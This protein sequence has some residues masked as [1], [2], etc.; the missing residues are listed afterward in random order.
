MF[1]DIGLSNGGFTAPYTRS[2]TR[3]VHL[4]KNED[5]K[6]NHQLLEDLK[7]RKDKLV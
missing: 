6:D 1:N 2:Y 3:W 4:L 5:K 7:L